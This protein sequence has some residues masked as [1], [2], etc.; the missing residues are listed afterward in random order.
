MRKPPP[1]CRTRGC[2][3]ARAATCGR[4]DARIAARITFM[5]PSRAS[6]GTASA[7][8]SVTCCGK[9]PGSSGRVPCE[10]APG[11][12]GR[13]APGRQPPCRP[14][15]LRAW[16]SV[17]CTWRLRGERRSLISA[18]LSHG[19]LTY[20]DLALEREREV[21]RARGALVDLWIAAPARVSAS[22]RSTGSTAPVHERELR[23]GD[24]NWS[25]RDRERASWSRPRMLRGCRHATCEHARGARARWRLHRARRQSRLHRPR[26]VVPSREARAVVPSRALAT[27]GSIARGASRGSIARAG[28]SRLL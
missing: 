4:C 11:F 19:Q 5:M 28:Q 16:S 21:C 15:G 26:A 13:P 3:R 20:A 12:F 14:S 2:A 17:S 6:E 25:E 18:L 7:I 1:L 9:R 24:L 22:R 23:F 8:R 10:T 27:G